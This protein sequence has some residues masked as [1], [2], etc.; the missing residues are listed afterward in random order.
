MFALTI[1]ERLSDLSLLYVTRYNP[2]K[3]FQA[4]PLCQYPA[5]LNV[6]QLKKNSE[7]KPYTQQIPVTCSPSLSS[8]A[9][10]SLLCLWSGWGMRRPAVRSEVGSEG[11]VGSCVDLSTSGVLPI[12]LPDPVR[13]AHPS[14]LV[15]VWSG[16]A[17]E[18]HGQILK[19]R[20]MP[21]QN[22]PL[23]MFFLSPVSSV[24]SPLFA[25]YSLALVCCLVVTAISDCIRK[26]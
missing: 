12:P 23:L 2:F 4:D 19:D 15:W 6:L 26:R 25:N 20:G 18:T 7:K 17:S 5:I 3:I 13:S 22:A 24:L 10:S 11:C 8:H 21:F 14:T 1:K 9:L 16:S